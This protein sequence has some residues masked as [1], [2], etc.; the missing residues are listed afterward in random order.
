MNPIDVLNNI[1]IANP[2]SISEM[3]YAIQAVS[4][5][6]DAAIQLKDAMDTPEKGPFDS[7]TVNRFHEADDR[8]CKALAAF[9]TGEVGD[10]R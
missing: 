10:G 1:R 2:A 4:E 3:R 6:V 5:L 9:Q 7:L 8:F